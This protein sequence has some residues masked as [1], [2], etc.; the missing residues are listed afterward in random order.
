MDIRLWFLMS[1]MPEAETLRRRIEHVPGSGF[2]S[3]RVLQLFESG[4]KTGFKLMK[5]G[6]PTESLRLLA[7]LMDAE[8]RDCEHLPEDERRAIGVQGRWYLRGITERVKRC[9]CQ[10]SWWQREWVLHLLPGLQSKRIKG[11]VRYIAECPADWR[12]TNAV[13]HG[14]YRW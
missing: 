1:D 2:R 6:R 8:L 5:G 11:R 10:I 14:L 9:M 12:M 13:Y 3:P 7:A 4:Y